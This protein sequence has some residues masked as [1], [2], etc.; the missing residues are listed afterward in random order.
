MAMPLAAAPGSSTRMAGTIPRLAAGVV[1]AASLG[2][3]PL[4]AQQNPPRASAPDAAAAAILR[5]Y[6]PI[7]AARLLQPEDANWLMIRRTYDG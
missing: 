3:L 4:L 7:T 6:Q 2:A 1:F 5:A